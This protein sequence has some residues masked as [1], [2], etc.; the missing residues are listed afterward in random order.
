MIKSAIIILANCIVYDEN[1]QKKQALS[2]HLNEIKKNINHL[3]AQRRA[4]Q[5]QQKNPQVKI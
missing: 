4:Q 1:T 2:F 3:Q 5:A